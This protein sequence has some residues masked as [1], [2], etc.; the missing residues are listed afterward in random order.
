MKTENTKQ[1]NLYDYILKDLIRDSIS[2][3]LVVTIPWFNFETLSRPPLK[4]AYPKMI[5]YKYFNES[6]FGD[7][8]KIYL[9]ESYGVIE[10]DIAYSIWGK[11]L[12]TL[13]SDGQ[14]G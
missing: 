6:L 13:F 7:R 1:N 10:D 14:T 5:T 12:D 8:F 4:E 9:K 2:S 3:G 11:Y